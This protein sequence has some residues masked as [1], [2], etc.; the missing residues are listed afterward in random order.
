MFKQ[1]LQKYP[2]KASITGCTDVGRVRKNNEDNFFVRDISLVPGSPFQCV[3]AVAD[4][5]GG[6]SRGEVAS[7]IVKQYLQEVFTD[8]NITALAGKVNDEEG[9]NSFL[10]QTVQ[11]INMRICA[12]SRNSEGGGSMGTTMTFGVQRG[13]TLFIAHVGDSRAYHLRGRDLVQITKDHSYVAEL[14]AA[15]VLS[16]KDAKVHPQRNVISRCLGNK[17]LVDVDVIPPLPL[18][19][20][21]YLLLCTDGLTGKVADKEIRDVILGEKDLNLAAK[22][23][24]D[25]AN[26]RGGEDNITVILAHFA[27]ESSSS[28]GDRATVRLGSALCGGKRPSSKKWLLIGMQL[29]AAAMVGAMVMMYYKGNGKT[30]D[31]AK[32]LRTQE[33]RSADAGKEGLPS[34]DT[35]WRADHATP[36]DA[37]GAAPVLEPENTGG[38]GEFRQID[39]MPEDAATQKARQEVGERAAA[40]AKLAETMVSTGALNEKQGDYRT[41]LETYKRALSLSPENTRALEG[42]ARCIEKLSGKGGTKSGKVNVKPIEKRK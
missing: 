31:A 2:L 6:L 27:G 10:K 37:Q 13:N 1:S 23:L 21:D 7:G 33:A 14:V 22:K 36:T 40:E 5:M 25:F 24:I 8:A 32:N 26:A 38:K 16:E 12:E 4:G 42:I 11:E 29:A 15:G 41:A 30:G 3:F 28:P 18:K 35:G 17:E 20:G 9:V 39:G 34:K 19:H